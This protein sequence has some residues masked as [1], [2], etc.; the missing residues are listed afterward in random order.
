VAIPTGAIYLQANILYTWVDGDVYEIP[1]TDQLEGAAS[2]ASFS[3]LGVVNQPH[4]LLLNKI[5]YT[6]AKQVVDETNISLLQIFKS[7]FTSSVGVNGY[8]KL[9]TQDVAHG[10]ISVI[11]QWGTIS[12]LGV[13]PAAL[14][15][16]VWPFN[17]PIAFPNAIWMLL[18]YWQSNDTAGDLA[19]GGAGALVLEAITP[20][21]KTGGVIATDRM[22]GIG[23]GTGDIYIQVAKSPNDGGGLTGIGWVAL[24]Y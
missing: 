9:G 15:N 11:L 8:L 7:L 20:L 13:S 23:T 12:L 17:F 18:P 16:A 5:Q 19:L 1:Q 4:Q 21:T 6:H 22:I 3:G 2:G 10:Q 24:G 14:K